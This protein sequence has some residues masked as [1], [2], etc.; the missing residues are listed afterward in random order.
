MIFQDP[1][2]A[3]NPVFRVGDQ[4]AE[5][6]RCHEKVGREEASRRAEE[7]LAAAGIPH[8]RQRARQFPHELSSGLNQRVLIA[9]A[10]AC[11]PSVLLADEP[12]SALDATTEMRILDL[13]SQKKEELGVGVVLITHDL[14]VM[15]RLCTRASVL[16]NGEILEEA[17]VKD[18]LEHPGH[19]YT[20]GLV[21]SLPTSSGPLTPIK[22]DPPDPFARPSGCV[23]EPRCP[24]AQKRCRQE[25]PSLRTL[26]HTLRRRV[27]C[28]FPLN[29]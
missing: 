26:N 15:E 17:G 24:K 21:K 27:R 14:R 9:M 16:Y 18:L 10:L 5:R 12:T 11:S 19:P 20:D 2:A 4:I 28:H 22:G 29:S 6:I 8:P 3:L 25:P 1:K 13:L 7:A 23:Y